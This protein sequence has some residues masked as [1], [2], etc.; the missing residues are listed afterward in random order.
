MSLAE[1]QFQIEY[2]E[3]DG[4]PIGETDVHI[5]WMI[6]LR[7]ILKHRYRSA[8]VYV[9]ADLMLYYVEG[10]PAKVVSPDVFVVK[11]CEQGFRRFC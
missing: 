8:R 3:S 1:I 11:D 7:D 9:A 4:Q 5:H 10:N 6:R 2:P